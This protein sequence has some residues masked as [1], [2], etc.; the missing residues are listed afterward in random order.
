[1]RK[2]KDWG[3]AVSIEKLGRKEIRDFL[4]W[5]YGQ[6][7]LHEGTNPGHTANKARE[8][9]RAVLSWAWDQELIATL[10]QFPKPRQQRGPVAAGLRQHQLERR[11]RFHHFEHH[12]I[13][14]SFRDRHS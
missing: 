4:D 10:P 11:R 3:G 8:H 1:M 7:R 13:T 5:V 14:R 12:A 2:S 6:A 9:L